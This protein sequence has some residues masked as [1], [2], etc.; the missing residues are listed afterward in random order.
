MSIV[1]LFTSHNTRLVIPFA[2]GSLHPNFASQNSTKL[3][4]IGKFGVDKNDKEN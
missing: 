1:N 2:F 4:I 3:N